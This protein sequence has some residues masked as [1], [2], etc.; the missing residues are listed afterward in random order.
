VK[1]DQLLGEMLAWIK[2]TDAKLPSERNPKYDP[3]A[4]PTKKAGRA[5]D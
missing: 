2:R 5:V 3:N 1:R 4:K